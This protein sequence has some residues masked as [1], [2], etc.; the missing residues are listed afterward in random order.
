MRPRRPELTFEDWVVNRFGRELFDTFFRSYTEKVWG[1]PCSEMSKDFA[2][3]RIRGLTLLGAVTGRARRWLGREGPKSLIERF[4]YPRL[5]PGQMWEAVRDQ[6]VA[7]G[8]EVRMG[9]PV[10]AIERGEDGVR[11]VRLAGGERIP[12]DVLFTTMPL[13]DVVAVM[14]PPAPEEIRSAAARLRFRDFL[15]VAI[16]VRRAE[17]FPDTW[18]YVHDPGVA[19]GRIQNYRNWSE[20]MVGDR[21]ATCLGLEYF[22]NRGD[23]LW[24][25]DDDELLVRAEREL[26][27]L[28]LV[29]PG[30]CAGGMVVRM[31][32]AY[33]VYDA[34]YRE[35]RELI[36]TWLEQ[37]VPNLHPA[38]RGGST[39]TT[40]R[41]TPWS[42]GCTP[43][44][45][46]EP[47]NGASTRGR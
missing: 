3:Q 13:R 15:T 34:G 32:D 12:A 16:V 43:S 18:I 33:P 6:V 29:E 8:G 1:I 11:G 44:P 23:E 2:A 40:A 14:E 36:R 24:D 4:L 37:E 17:V 21:S 7:G 41:T 20:A 45:T 26:V 38:G 35:H 47:A 46:P 9:A 25:E 10:D 5:G 22:C 27:A 42:P 31:A 39:T 28:G 19:V 30:E